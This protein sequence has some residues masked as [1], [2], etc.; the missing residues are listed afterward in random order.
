[1][2]GVPARKFKTYVTEAETQGQ[3]AKRRYS[4]VQ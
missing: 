2:K 1:M 4:V 3:E